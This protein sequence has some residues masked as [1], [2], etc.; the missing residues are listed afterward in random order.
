MIIFNVHV[1]NILFLYLQKNLNDALMGILR[2]RNLISP[3]YVSTRPSLNV[4][5]ITK[6]DHFVI[7]AS[8]GLFDFFT[9]EETVDLVGCYIVSNPSGDPA[10]FLLEHLV[11]RAAECAGKPL[12]ALSLNLVMHFCLFHHNCEQVTSSILILFRY[13]RIIHCGIFLHIR[14]LL[15]ENLIFINEFSIYIVICIRIVQSCYLVVSQFSANDHNSHTMIFF[16]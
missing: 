1:D 6:S 7:V 14:I 9:N 15:C 16:W 4:H 11:E 2:V 8:D 3:P 13:I 5:R 10:K 12:I